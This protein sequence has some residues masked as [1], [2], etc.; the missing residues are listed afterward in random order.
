MEWVNEIEGWQHIPERCKHSHYRAYRDN[1]VN[2]VGRIFWEQR[3]RR[4][5]RPSCIGCSICEWED[6][7]LHDL[8]ECS[9]E[10]PFNFNELKLGL[11]YTLHVTKVEDPCSCGDSWSPVGEFTLRRNEE[12]PLDYRIKNK[13]SEEGEILA[14]ELRPEVVVEALVKRDREQGECASTCIGRYFR[15]R[16]QNYFGQRESICSRIVLHPLK[17]DSCPGCPICAWVDK[18]SYIHT[19]HESMID[20]PDSSMHGKKVCLVPQLSYI[21]GE[22]RLLHVN[23]FVVPEDEE[24]KGTVEGKV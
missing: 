23:Y 3:V 6:D 11:A 24:E 20:I 18:L 19:G 8:L 5:R 21:D 2:H 22:V 13:V 16:V 15:V 1:Y 4:L 17:R 14:S 9:G 7:E 10:F 12:I